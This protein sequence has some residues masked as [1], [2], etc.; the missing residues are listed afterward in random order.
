ML[1]P[2]ARIRS[3]YGKKEIAVS[4]NCVKENKDG[5]KGRI[6]KIS[7][8]EIQVYLLRDEGGMDGGRMSILMGTTQ[9]GVTGANT[10]GST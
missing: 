10:T 3:V 2:M 9:M 1:H 7:G 8:D 6:W 5:S 4:R